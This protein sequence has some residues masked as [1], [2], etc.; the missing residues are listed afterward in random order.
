MASVNLVL[1]QANEVVLGVVVLG[2]IVSAIALL[3][4]DEFVSLREKL[5]RKEDK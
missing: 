3:V 2:I 5:A 4:V 1:Q